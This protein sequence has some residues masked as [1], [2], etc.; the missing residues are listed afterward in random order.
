VYSDFLDF[1]QFLDFLSHDKR[2]VHFGFNVQRYIINMNYELIIM[3]FFGFLN[4]SA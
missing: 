3:N 1:L 2:S 4:F